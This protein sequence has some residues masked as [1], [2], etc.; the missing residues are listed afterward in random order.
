MTCPLCIR[1]QKTQWIFED[2][3]VSV[4]YCD[5]CGV[6]LLVL[7]RH[8]MSPSEAEVAYMRHRAYVIGN[9]T[10]GEGRFYVDP[11]QRKIKDHLH[12]HIRMK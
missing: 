7:N 6:P 1:K 10:Y 8:T 11:K 3:I 4:F 12:W 2:D 5:T 9:E